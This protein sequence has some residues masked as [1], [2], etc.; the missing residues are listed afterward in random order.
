MPNEPQI[1]YRKPVWVSMPEIKRDENW[2]WFRK[3][4]SS[5]IQASLKDVLE[6]KRKEALK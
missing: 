2:V 6:W 4:A 5:T 1:H 3:S